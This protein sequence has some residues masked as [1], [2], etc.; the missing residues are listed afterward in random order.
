MGKLKLMKDFLCNIGY[1]NALIFSN[2]YYTSA[3]VGVAN[4][5]V[6]YEYDRMVKE[7][8]E[9]EQIEIEDAIDFIE[10][11]T[12]RA[13]SQTVDAPI[14]F[15]EIKDAELRREYLMDDDTVILY[16]LEF[17]DAFIGI[18]VETG[19]AVYSYDEMIRSLCY[20]EKITEEDAIDYIESVIDK[21][22]EEFPDETTR[23]IILYEVDLDEF[24]ETVLA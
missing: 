21:M 2:P 23:P 12:L 5:R 14:V 3:F 8:A 10:Y 7:L 13:L 4:K 6:V 22:E 9:T 24:A 18:R 1:D 15:Y 16:Q 11:D 20:Y 19:Q 17:D